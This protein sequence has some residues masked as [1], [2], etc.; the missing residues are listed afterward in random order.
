MTFKMNAMEKGLSL[1]IPHGLIIYWS[2]SNFLNANKLE[3][4]DLST[5]FI[6]YISVLLLAVVL[7]W[8]ALKIFPRHRACVFITFYSFFFVI[9]LTPSI[10]ELL[11][12]YMRYR[13]TLSLALLLAL[14]LSYLGCRLFS[15]NK[16]LFSYI[17]FFL[18]LSAAPTGEYLAFKVTAEGYE[19][20][21]QLK[22]EGQSANR[23]N[24]YFILL[25]AYMRSDILKRNL[26][27]DNSEFMSFLEDRKF[28]NASGSFVA[29][30]TTT[31]SMVSTF[32]M[33]HVTEMEPDIWSKRFRSDTFRI[34]QDLGYSSHFISQNRGV[35]PCPVNVTCYNETP[36]SGFL[37]VGRLGTILVK[38]IPLLEDVLLA[39]APH[40]FIYELNEVSDLH[41]T[42]RAF[43]P[44]KPSFFYAHISMPHSP[45]IRDAECGPAD[46]TQSG[47][48]KSFRWNIR[49]KYTDF[50][51]C[52]NQQVMDA[53]TTLIDKDPGAIIIL[54]GDHGAYFSYQ[55]HSGSDGVPEPGSE[56]WRVP[57]L[58]GAYAA[59][60]AM[61]VPPGCRKN[62]YSAMSPVNTFRMVF[63]CIT[64]NKPEYIP[65]KSFWIDYKNE[66]INLIRQGGKW[67]F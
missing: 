64:G 8:S 28:F 2:A 54:Q 42:L 13:Y 16:F 67:L 15:G 41:D 7:T 52:G 46:I 10:R 60:N 45:Y 53:I 40:R 32:R 4:F 24:V 30:A 27:F 25:D 23:P 63:A 39:L 56:P 18:L 48:F 33:Q 22:F 36:K 57:A 62:L 14:S 17:I 47:D 38:T 51:Q 19:N 6:F 34:F 66:K 50:L 11:D 3:Y 35:I 31:Y 20:K 37:Y 21:S 55:K 26:N 9:F 65:D 49:H 58:E 5:A 59:L 61:R 43:A 29:Y 1:Y 44:D 12:P